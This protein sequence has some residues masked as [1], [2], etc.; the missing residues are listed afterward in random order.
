MTSR[1]M[2]IAIFLNPTVHFAKVPMPVF[3]SVRL[4]SV[5]LS[6][7]GYV[8][9]ADPA[10][11]TVTCNNGNIT[12]TRD[13][14]GVVSGGP[15][16]D[17]TSSQ[18]SLINNLSGSF[19][20]DAT[21]Y[22]VNEQPV[23][24]CRTCGG[25]AAS[26][27]NGLPGLTLAR[28]YRSRVM[29]LHGSLGYDHFLSTDTHLILTWAADGTGVVVRYFDP[30][31]LNTKIQ[32][33]EKLG[34]DT[35]N[36]GIL[37]T[38]VG[39]FR[40][41]RLY[42]AAQTLTASGLAATTAVITDVDGSSKAFELV[43]VAGSATSGYARLVRITNRAGVNV[44]ALTYRYAASASLAELGNDRSRLWQ[45]ATVIAADQTQA[46][47][48]YDTVKR[49]GRFSVA[50]IA[51][52]NG[53]TTAFRY[54][55]SDLIANDLPGR[56]TATFT[57]SYDTALQKIKTV[58]ND[59]AAEAGHQQKTVWW[60]GTSYVLPTGATISQTEGQVFR[61]DN[62]AG[63]TAYMAWSDTTLSDSYAANKTVWSSEKG[64]EYFEVTAAAAQMKAYSRAPG[65]VLG[66][67][68]SKAVFTE[69]KTFVNDT[70]H[71]LAKSQIDSVGRAKSF[72]F[73]VSTRRL[74]AVTDEAGATHSATYTDRALPLTT[75][76]ETG[77]VTTYTYDTQGN[78]LSKT[79]GSGVEA[80]TWQWGY[81][82]NGLV[83]DEIDANGNRT[84]YEYDAVGHLT[85][86]IEPA[87][88][89]GGTRYVRTFSYDAAGRMQ[90]ASDEAGRTTTYGYDA[91]NRLI[92]RLYADG[93]SE[94]ITYGNGATAGLVVATTDRNGVVTTYEYDATGRRVTTRVADGRSEV[95]VETV[96]YA[97]GSANRMLTR[98]RD[99]DT[100]VY[101]YDDAG[102]VV[103]ETTLPHLNQA[104]ITRHAYDQAV[105]RFASEDRYGRWTYQA[106]DPLDR[107]T[108][109]L[110]EL[111][112]GALGTPEQF[113][114][115][116]V[117]AYPSL[118]FSGTDI[119]GPALA[120]SSSVAGGVIT[121]K[122][123]GSDI[124]N[125]AD[126]FQFYARPLA[127][128]ATLVVHLDSQT[129]PDG[130]SKAGIMLRA[131]AAADAAFVDVIVSSGGVLVQYRTATGGL[132]AWPG[133]IALPGQKAP[134]WLQA[135]LVGTTATLS[136]SV[137]GQAWTT[138][139][140]VPF[141]RQ[142]GARIGLAVTSH[143][144]TA[145]STAVFS[146]LSLQVGAADP[147]QATVL[148]NDTFAS[149]VRPTGANPSFVIED[150]AY[151]A[152]GRITARIDGRGVR[153]TRMYDSQGRLAT[154]TEAAGTA[155]AA[156]TAFAYDAQGNQISVTD[157]RGAVTAMRFT[158]RNLLAS[159]TEASGTAIA[160]TTAYAY[161]P[162]SKVL[163]STDPLLRTTVNTYGVCCDRLVAIQDPL[164][165]VTR[166]AYD[167]VGN[168]TM[169][170]DAN[171]LTTVTAYDGRNRPVS[172]T[173]AAG[174]MTQMAY[175]DN[176]SALTATAGLDLGAGAD[177][178]AAITTNPKGESSTE[179]YDGLGRVVRRV[180]GLGHATTF[181]YDVLVTDGGVSLMAMTTTDAVGA[182]TTGLFDGAGRSR[183]TLDALGQRATA[184]FDANGSR[185]IWRD[186]N[187]IGQDCVFDSRNRDVQCTDTAGAVTRR[188]YDAMNNI[189][190]SVDALGKTDSAVFDLR[191]RRVS[192]TDR[193]AATTTFSYDLGSNLLSITDAEDGLTAYWY[194]ARNL[195][196]REIFPTG[197][198]GRTARYYAYDAGR[199][200]ISRSVAP[201]A[202]TGPAPETIPPASET[203]SYA[204]DNANRLVQRGYPDA[205]NDIFAY[206]VAS[207]L[208]VATSA[209][210]VNQ[211]ARTYDA[212]GRLTKETLS[213]TAPAEA[214]DLLVAYAYDNANR[215]T[216]LTYPDGSQVSRAYTVRGELQQVWDGGTSLA[217]RT[218]DASGRLTATLL[219][220]QLTETRTYVPNDNLVA[221]IQV[222]GV[223]NFA[224]QYDADKRKTVEQD[225]QIAD[226]SQR[227]AY[228][229]QNRVSAWKRGTGMAPADPSVEAA[230]W[231]LTPVGDWATVAKTVGATTTTENRTHSA[232]HE[233]LSI[234]GTALAYDA[235]GNLIRD[236]QGQTF[237]WDFENC[238]RVA[239]H[240]SQGQGDSS[241]YSYDALGRR[242]KRAVVTAGKTVSTYFVNA[243]AQEVVA[244]TGDITAFNDP[245][246]DPEDAGA[247]PFNSATGAGARGS[248]L[249]DP[250]AQ[251]MNFQPASTDTP[252]GWLSE[253]GAMRLNAS[254]LGWNTAV[255]GVDR[256]HLGRPL[257]DSFIP[258]GASTWQVPVANGTHAVVIVCGDADS[259]AQTNDLIVNGVV[260]TDPTPFDGQIVHGYETGSFDGYAITV[261][262][263][264]GL[265][266]IVSG[267]GALNPKLNFIEI[268]T[269]G[270]SAD[271]AAIARVTAA[272]DKATHD[273]AKPKAKY[274]PLVRRSVF[275][276]SYPDNV[277]SYA[278]RKP[279]HASKRFFVA[280]NTS[281]TPSAVTDSVGVVLSRYSYDAYGRQTIKDPSGIIVSGDPASLERSFTGYVL[282]GETGMNYARA[283][284]Y[285]PKLGRFSGRDA[286][287]KNYFSPGS[288]DGYV[289]GM[290]LYAGYFAINGVD[291]FGLSDCWNV[292]R[293][294]LPPHGFM[295]ETNPNAAH[296][297]E[298]TFNESC[299]P[300]CCESVKLNQQISW[301]GGST[302]HSD[303]A[304]PGDN[305]HTGPTQPGSHYAND[306]P[307]HYIDSPQRGFSAESNIKICAVCVKKDGSESNISCIEF[308]FSKSTGD[309]NL[310]NSHRRNGEP[311]GP[312][313]R[314]HF[315]P[316][317]PP[318][319]PPCGGR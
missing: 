232:V 159:Q 191:N 186:A 5:L 224:Y 227:F 163:T 84:D 118:P 184:G 221:T 32:F 276:D 88:V 35:L 258:L 304:Q 111:V 165:F 305:N 256:D 148:V 119:G 308:S 286:V 158:G 10:T 257:Y 209:R 4:L 195:L 301:D 290:S 187:G 143:K 255:M 110:R 49:A 213:F 136:A 39:L 230:T 218:Y 44:Q 162:T 147:A 80:A 152:S 278:I 113:V 93:S 103:S 225:L 99:G 38:S 212:A 179:I 208:T 62:A 124:W 95:S 15:E 241:I 317:V 68:L 180:D 318:L 267:S 45:V 202:T 117:A 141:Q 253:L 57:R 123:G 282:D 46:T 157:A 98:V 12:C 197:Q 14:S 42:D 189:V 125:A 251:R 249:A 205:K 277:A 173:N 7:I 287:R 16:C 280:S 319:V 120:G 94:S 127:S 144:V 270:T 283:R 228:D 175:F 106:F 8:Q 53:T 18:H 72:S 91:A 312:E 217:A 216:G 114:Q 83:A 222:P 261:D 263:T 135:S 268:G 285:S 126:Q 272:A 307:Y 64:L 24:G 61:R 178:S 59:T 206:D 76:D 56:G 238:L 139:G 309:I 279:R 122:G 108:R 115:Q 55:G 43:N 48:T 243:G 133:S 17:A 294:H 220:N 281:Y 211:V 54:S 295:N 65:F 52:P 36:D 167:F 244:I 219:G 82:A 302:Y 316:G 51:L 171:N 33:G 3:R 47:Y 67:D 75:T 70:A 60:S 166:F 193:V 104:L 303:N 185:V 107:V 87:D 274:P 140:T 145:L 58:I 90:T 9:A 25:D 112:P 177:G 183:V 128:D 27:P 109:T 194:D 252:D 235:K 214:A 168:R 266:T 160:A 130:W 262:V 233:L 153:S 288:S 31:D 96:T 155:D 315:N 296:A 210:Y 169:V 29:D 28:Y 100:T 63:E 245:D 78:R 192:T 151:D 204:Y 131:S 265:L 200:L 85:R 19:V 181:G 182:T 229:D 89:S 37:H 137:D 269:I 292:N 199:R 149:L 40:D 50:S 150:T 154:I 314:D 21:I 259:R 271:P 223:T 170:T 121:M 264:N 142:V 23:G 226:Q 248:L 172:V 313:N 20:H 30:A 132:A 297:F 97:S 299:K 236:D 41:L 306:P 239:D 240:L 13:C 242:V 300:P 196:D 73:D 11:W 298:V 34:A 231:T 254:A 1:Y 74:L 6:A 66:Q 79:T 234:N 215:V 237:V 250:A 188:V 207:R 260:V 138:V 22:G 273:T 201:I 101:S 291:P 105:R 26:S 164:G 246:A 134:V 86:K 2:P 275:G 174:E 156:T 81:L 293:T 129:Q 102:H 92:S 161:S 284:W 116:A 176:A 289:D 190:A 77:R 71:V 203:T 146:G 247:V 198:A 310:P 311:S 69:R